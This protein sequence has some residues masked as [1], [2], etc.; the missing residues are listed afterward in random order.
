M[1][2][3]AGVGFRLFACGFR[4]FRLLVSRTVRTMR[5]AYTPVKNLPQNIGI[6]LS[7]RRYLFPLLS[8]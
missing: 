4:G 2:F 1:D 7:L 5:L 6:I 8:Y 3:V